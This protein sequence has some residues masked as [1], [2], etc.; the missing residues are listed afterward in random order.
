MSL[1][2]KLVILVVS[3][4]LVTLLGVYFFQSTQ[5]RQHMQQNQ[6][7]WV[8]TLTNT[9]SESVATDTINGN[10]IP[11]TELLQ[12]IVEDEA[13]EFAYVTDM[14]GELFAHSF[15]KGFPRFLHKHLHKHA[16][17][18]EHSHLDAKYITKQGEIVEFDSPLVKGLTAR[19]HLGINQNEINTLIRNVQRDFF[20]FML[21]ITMLGVFFA[22]IVG[23]RINSPLTEF[24]QKLLSYSRDNRNKFPKINTSDPVIKNLVKVFSDVINERDKAADSNI[25]SQ[26]RLFL[27]RQLSPIG[28]IEWKTDFTFVDFNPAAEKIFG[29][30]KNEVLGHHITDNILPESAREHVDKVWQALIANTGGSHSIN[31]NKT[32]NGEIITCEWYNTP[33]VN[34]EGEV[35]GVASF[36]E[37]ITE[38]KHQEE[39]IRRTQKMDALG[40]LTGGVSHDFNNMLGVILGYAELLKMRLEKEDDLRGYVDE[41]MHAGE[42]GTNLTKKLLSFS[43]QKATEAMSVDLNQVLKDNQDL[44]EKTLTARIK[45]IYDLDVAAWPIYVDSNDLEDMLL[46]LSINAMHAMEEGGQLSL[47]TR[48]E[49]LSYHDAYLLGIHDGEY[50]VFSIT[51]TGCGMDD[52]TLSHIFEPFYSTKGQ[53]GTGLGLS[54]V[55]GFIQRSGGAIK[56]YSEVDHGSQFVV[57]FPVDNNKSPD[58]IGLS[59]TGTASLKGTETILVVDDEAPLRSLLKTILQEHGYTVFLA[60]SGK[61][62]LSVLEENSVDAVISDVIMPEMDGYQLA[63]K[64]VTDYPAIKVQ[65]VSGFTDDRHNEHVTEELHKKLLYKPVNSKVLLK[66]LRELLDND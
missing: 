41:I 7:E 18:I 28:I 46:N 6:L 24:S 32:K 13:I 3:I 40:K 53:K 26:Q 42:R 10:K 15:Y 23:R 16:D 22:F 14:D 2:N 29:F 35:V 52:E 47:Q 5:I 43:K 30:T 20:L 63:N 39:L 12:R 51:D 64:I 25:E 45:L 60:E 9:L 34:D 44:L 8:E 54:Q 55:Y 4:I 38:K 19:I 59:D 36:V 56:A 50:V 58:T 66:R 33:L 27:H 21:F 65:L 57:Y 31:E 61:Q 11:V 17:T 49:Y 48:N 37:D 1:T 62:A